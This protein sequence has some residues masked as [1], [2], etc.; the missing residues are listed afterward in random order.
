M[1]QEI[2]P[3]RWIDEN[4]Y[5]IEYLEDEKRRL[6]RSKPKRYK[7]IPFDD[8]GMISKETILKFLED[9]RDKLKK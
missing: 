3:R 8:D 4:L 1:Y 6:E 7:T 5:S 2:K 9:N